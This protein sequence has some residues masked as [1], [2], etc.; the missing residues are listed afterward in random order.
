V[1]FGLNYVLAEAGGSLFLSNRNEIVANISQSFDA[2]LKVF[3]DDL[4]PRT[5]CSVT[6][7]LAMFH[8]SRH[9][10]LNS[11]VLESVLPVHLA[12]MEPPAPGG[13]SP[14]CSIS[15]GD[16]ALCLAYLSRDFK[17]RYLLA[18]CVHMN[19]ICRW[20]ADLIVALIQENSRL[21]FHIVGECLL[22][23]GKS[24]FAVSRSHVFVKH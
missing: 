24:V 7:S 23:I 3:P 14:I 9:E 20:L 4:A 21:H 16:T 22:G 1:L 12:N 10:L 11:G 19:A 8:F 18:T 17:G 2:A 5:V 13:M 15:A 6:R